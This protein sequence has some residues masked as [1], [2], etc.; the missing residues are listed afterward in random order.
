MDQVDAVQSATVTSWVI[1]AQDWLSAYPRRVRMACR[2]G[3]ETNVLWK[4]DSAGPSWM[5]FDII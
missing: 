3:L 2:M 1:P 4:G 5:M